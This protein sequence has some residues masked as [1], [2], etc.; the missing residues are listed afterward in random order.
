G[1]L[2][3]AN[4]GPTTTCGGSLTTTAPSTIT[5]TG[6]SLT[7]NSNCTFN[8]TVTGASAGTKDNT[9]TA[10]TST[11]GGNGNTATASLV[12]NNQ[13]AS[14][15]LTKQVST[16]G[17]DPWST[18]IGVNSGSNVYYRFKVYNSGDLPFTAISVS[19]P[20]L[21]GTLADPA[22]CNWAASL[23]LA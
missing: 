12:V 22:T 13:T 2:T 9:T 23:P 21:A 20:A 10:V 15:D 18:F 14:L 1:G 17:T 16:T 3:V 8:V 5:F 4:S 6:G 7:A 11:E 19:D